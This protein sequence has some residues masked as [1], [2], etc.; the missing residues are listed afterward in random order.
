MLGDFL[1]LFFSL[2]YPQA[3]CLVSFYIYIQISPRE[4]IQRFPS[5]CLIPALWMVRTSRNECAIPSCLLVRHSFCNVPF[6]VFCGVAAVV[7]PASGVGGE[8][9]GRE[10]K[11]D[12]SRPRNGGDRCNKPPERRKPSPP[13]PPLSFAGIKDA[14]TYISK[15]TKRCPSLSVRVSAA[16]PSRRRSREISARRR[17][18]FGKY[19]IQTETLF[20]TVVGR[21]RGSPSRFP[22]ESTF[23]LQEL[24][25]FSLLAA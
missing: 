7:G 11:A 1:F 18:K 19:V 9:R 5:T 25:N 20:L 4:N 17:E 14:R 23:R 22:E 3:R 2:F 13:P 24:E 15:F 21:Q 10:R 8:R 16:F 12:K 6:A